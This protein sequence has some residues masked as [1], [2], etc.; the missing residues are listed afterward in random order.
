MELATAATKEEEALSSFIY[1]LKSKGTQEQ[2][3]FRLKIF[4][5]FMGLASSSSS[6]SSSTASIEEQAAIFLDKVKQNPPEW[7]E[8]S[9][10][11]F[12]TDNKR[13]IEENKLSATSLSNYV[14][15]V[16]LFYEMNNIPFNWKRIS[17]GI[18]KARSI[19]NDRAPTIEEIQKIVEYSDRRIKSI[20]YV[21][22]SS[23]IRVGAWEWLKWKHVIPMPNGDGIAKLI[24]YAGESEEYFS[25]ISPEAYN[26]LKAYMDFRASYGE[27]IT[28]ESWLMRD[29]F[30]TSSVTRNQRF[31]LAKY[32]RKITEEGITKLLSRAI[33]EENIRGPLKEGQRRYEWKTSHG[34]RKFFCTRAEQVMK[35]LNVQILMGHNIGL[36]GSYLKPTE[37]D[38]LEDYKKAVNLLTINYDNNSELQEQ[39]TELTQKSQEQTYVIQGRLAEKDKELQELQDKMTVLQANTAN[40]LKLFITQGKHIDAEGERNGELALYAYDKEQGPAAAAKAIREAE[41]KK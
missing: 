37:Q 28:G 3:L 22:C 25:F 12:I 39:V 29:L 9:L 36:I 1:A 38:L 30:R 4:F 41:K 18:P 11:R 35:P 21:M 27:K 23:G 20:V 33:D 19:A 13:K 32:P 40:L 7:A 6:S 10:I 14:I 26:E 24:V 17:R 34:L 15:A 2:Y 8:N 5:N 16:R 31:G